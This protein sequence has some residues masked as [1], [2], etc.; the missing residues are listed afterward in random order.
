MRVLLV[1]TSSLGDV[2]H[3]LPA[4]TDAAREHAGIRF[5]WLV[6]EGFAAIPAWHPSV[7]RVIPV[8]LRRWRKQPLAAVRSGQWRAFRRALKAQTYDCVIDAQG[9]IKS[10]LLARMARGPLVGPDRRA[11]REPWASLAY[12]KRVSIPARAEAHAITRVR[13]LFAAALGYRVPA[14]EPDYGLDGRLFSA[15]STVQPY[16]MFLHGTTWTTKLWPQTYWVELARRVTAAGLAVRLAHGNEAEYIRA[17]HIAAA[18]GAIV[19]PSM[20]LAELAGEI[21]AARAVVSVDT[22]LAH[23][24]AALG[25]PGVTLYGATEPSL[26]GAWGRQQHNLSVEFPCAPCMSR[27]CL[28]GAEGDIWPGCFSTLR[29]E[30]VWAVLEPLLHGAARARG[31]YGAP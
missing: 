4:L 15:A 2:V 3:A 1:K 13:H 26:T 11:A 27:R 10:A 18:G 23:V 9:L 19:L 22:G 5:D 16:V 7:D 21:A 14:G 28:H 6:E 20:G 29:P 17:Q 12:A 31:V 30:S 25:V 8:A 24:A